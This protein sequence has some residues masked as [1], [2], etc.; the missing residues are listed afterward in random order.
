MCIL[1]KIEEVGSNKVAATTSL[2]IAEFTGK[3]HKNVLADIENLTAE[4]SAVNFVK[5][6]LYK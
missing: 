5:G 2:K 3:E 1:V 4:F 6:G